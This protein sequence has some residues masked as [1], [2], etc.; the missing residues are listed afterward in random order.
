M[1]LVAQYM[2]CKLVG[3]QACHAMHCPISLVMQHWLLSEGWRRDQHRPMGHV[4]CEGLYIYLHLFQTF[5]YWL[6]VISSV[7]LPILPNTLFDRRSIFEELSVCDRL[8]DPTLSFDSFPGNYLKSRIICELLNILNAVEM[9]HD[10][11]LYKFTN[12]IDIHCQDKN[13]GELRGTYSAS[14]SSASFF[15][16]SSSTFRFSS[17]AMSFW[18]SRSLRSASIWDWISAIF[19]FDRPL[20]VACSN[21]Q[22]Q[23]TDDP[24]NLF[25]KYC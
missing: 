4:A 17:S 22:T 19:S 8:L 21:R 12:D 2:W 14:A 9:L 18:P 24:Q 6:S 15:S 11:V 1:W 7:T 23:H 16:R 13:S 20:P 10:S 5:L 25:L 3:K